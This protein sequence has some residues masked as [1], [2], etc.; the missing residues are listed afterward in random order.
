MGFLE[1]N[2]WYWNLLWR[3]QLFQ[4]ELEQLED[5][6]NLLEAVI[7]SYN[8]EDKTW[9]SF[10]KHGEFSVKSFSLA[11]Y[12]ENSLMCDEQQIPSVWRGVA[13][14][15]DELLLWF[16]LKGR[17][18]TR[19][20][21]KT[22]RILNIDGEDGL[23]PFCKEEEESIAHLF[24]HCKFSWRIWMDVI[25]WWGSQIPMAY[26]PTEWFIIWSEACLKLVFRGVLVPL[27]SSK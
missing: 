11:C 22:L 15:R 3:R 12:N 6:L 1:E 27:G 26:S 9:S 18:N 21:L 20:R 4:W 8:N 16:I 10:D 2:K 17:L 24:L 25:N 7:L 14:P 5:L 23:C 13:P 19:S